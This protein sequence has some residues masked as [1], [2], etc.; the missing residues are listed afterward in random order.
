MYDQYL[1]WCREHENTNP[2]SA[3]TYRDTFNTQFNLGFGSPKSDTC[4]TCD[5]GVESQEHKHRANLA[6]EMQKRDKEKAANDIQHKFITF[7]LQKTLPL[8]KLSTSVA[9][10]L[11]Q[12]W[13]YNLGVHLV[14]GNISNGYFQLWTEDQG[15]RGCE[16]VASAIMCFLDASNL[17]G[18]QLTTWSDSCAGQNKNFVILSLWQFLVATG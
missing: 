9:F 13:L 5:S 16:E 7:D 12:L 10:Y 15:G 2:A 3:R 14:S 18:G 17:K 8:P 11:R 6:F 4:T 1:L